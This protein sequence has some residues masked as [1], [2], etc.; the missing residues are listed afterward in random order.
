MPL[1]LVP[2]PDPVEPPRSPLGALDPIWTAV[3][4]LAGPRR[5]DRDDRTDAGDGRRSR[6]EPRLARLVPRDPG[7]DDGRDGAPVGRADGAAVHAHL[8]AT[9][10]AATDRFR[11]DVVVRR[12]L[13]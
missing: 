8:A 10:A 11:A 1:S 2:K 12:Q 5:V 13:P 4:L 9:A 7:D 6:H 3:I